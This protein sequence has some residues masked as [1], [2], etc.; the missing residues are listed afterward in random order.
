MMKTPRLLIRALSPGDRESFVRS[1]RERGLC[2]MYGFPEDM[3]EQ[4]AS[5]VFDHFAARPSAYALLSRPA[6][7]LIGFALDVPSELPAEM[8]AGLPPRGRSF[9][10]AVFAPYRRR[11]YMCEALQSMIASAFRGG[12]GYIHCGHFDFNEPG[13]LLLKR[14]GFT[15]YGR[16]A[17]GGK[18]IIDE[19]LFND[20]AA[21]GKKE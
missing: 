16:H 3:D 17:L 5:A 18:T 15:K 20:P 9:A 11:G 13:A 2:R 8:R 6:G 10:Y 4:T 14:L 19:I 21:P 7:E 1:V 12:A